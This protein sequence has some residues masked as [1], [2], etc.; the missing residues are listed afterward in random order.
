MTGTEIRDILF[1][2]YKNETLSGNKTDFCTVLLAGANA[3]GVLEQIKW[4]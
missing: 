3:I 4:E 2:A 1:K